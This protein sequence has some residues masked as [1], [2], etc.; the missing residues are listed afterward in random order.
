LDE[1][2]VDLAYY[3]LSDDAAL[4]AK[5]DYKKRKPTV[6]EYVFN[7]LPQDIRLSI[8]EKLKQKSKPYE[9][10]TV[11]DAQVFMRP[12]LYRK[13]RMSLGMWTIEEDETGYSDEIA[14]RILEEDSDWQR[15]P[16]KAA[17][18]NKLEL[19]P[20]KLSYVG[21]EPYSISRN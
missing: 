15:N 13:I 16:E 4:K 12:K 5:Y 17:I 1:Y 10:I 18:V 6:S 11:A 7:L 8:N 2:A 14:Y 19:F 20:L 9:G 3:P 21:N